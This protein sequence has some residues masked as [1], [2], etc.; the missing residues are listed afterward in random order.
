MKVSCDQ[1]NSSEKGIL[2]NNN[3]QVLSKSHATCGTLFVDHA[4][5]FTFNFIQT[6]TEASQTVEGKDKF[7][8]FAK[9]CG[10]SVAHYHV[11]NKIFTS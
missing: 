3:G 5:D 9:S 8:I 2:A 11:D 10:V 4:S 7:K 1:H 6:S